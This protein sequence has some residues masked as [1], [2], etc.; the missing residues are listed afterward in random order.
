M[1]T[2]LK[3]PNTFFMLFEI[4]RFEINYRLR[5]YNTWLYFIILF[6]F[7]IVAVDFVFEGQPGPLKRNAPMIIAR[8]MGIVAA[9]SMMIP[10]MIMGVAVLRDFD[11]RMESLLFVNPVKKR[12]YLFGRWLGSFVILVF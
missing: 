3:S 5:Q 7:S 12:D 10:S 11:H 8:T 1:C 4:F 9:L 2:S 6:L